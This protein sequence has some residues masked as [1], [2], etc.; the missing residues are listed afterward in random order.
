MK[1]LLTA[2]V[3][4][5]VEEIAVDGSKVLC[6]AVEGADGNIYWVLEEN[7]RRVYEDA[8]MILID[9]LDWLS[10]DGKRVAQVAK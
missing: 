8:K 9:P 7:R 5:K 1:P 4:D 3:L 6:R 10:D 2:K